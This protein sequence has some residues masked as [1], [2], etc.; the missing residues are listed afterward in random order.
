MQCLQRYQRS[1]N[2]QLLKSTWSKEDDERLK[3]AVAELGKG[4]WQMG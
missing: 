3:N 4:N 1:L 2:S